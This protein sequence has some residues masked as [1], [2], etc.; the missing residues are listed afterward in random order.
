MAQDTS[1]SELLAIEEFLARRAADP[2]ADFNA[3]LAQRDK[4]I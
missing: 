2:N 4:A 3:H 1:L